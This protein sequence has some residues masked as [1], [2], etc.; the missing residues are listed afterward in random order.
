MNIL[1]FYKVYHGNFKVFPKVDFL[2]PSALQWH[3]ME[4]R[5][6]CATKKYNIKSEHGCYGYHVETRDK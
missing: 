4:I 1:I 5:R 6:V 2:Q 3:T